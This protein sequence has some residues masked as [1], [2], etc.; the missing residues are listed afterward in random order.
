MGVFHYHLP[1]EMAGRVAA[2]HLVEVPFG[3]QQVQGVVLRPIAAPEVPETRPVNGL[4]DD[5]PAL[6]SNQLALAAWLAEDTL[7]P[8]AACVSL[9]LPPGLSKQADTR[10]TLLDERPNDLSKLQARLVR[11]LEERG[12]LRGRQ[13]DALLP[14]TK[15]QRTAQ[16]LVR[17]GVLASQPVLPPP[18]VAPKQVRTVQLAVSPTEAAAVVDDLG[19]PRSH[20]LAVRSAR[21]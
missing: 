15:W 17:R 21:S 19:R 13:I 20:Q 16:N 11:L 1:P 12:P 5:Q 4:L 10:Y 3:R 8:L 18:S 2:G 7:A 6:N 9:M 14:R